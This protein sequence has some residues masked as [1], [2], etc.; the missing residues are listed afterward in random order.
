MNKQG[1]K[2]LQHTPTLYR[3][4]S[5]VPSTSVYRKL[6]DALN[7]HSQSIELIPKAT[8]ALYVTL[9]DFP[10]ELHAPL[11]MESG[12]QQQTWLSICVKPLAENLTLD[13]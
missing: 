6:G 3:F 1:S 4:A 13:K 5:P 2:Q 7:S 10:A 11:G 12:I 8:P 9:P